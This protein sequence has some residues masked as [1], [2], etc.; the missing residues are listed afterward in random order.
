MPKE[1]NPE[2]YYEYPSGSYVCG[3]CLDEDLART[4][5][6]ELVGDERVFQGMFRRLPDGDTEDFAY[7]CDGCLKQNAA[8]DLLGAEE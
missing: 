2:H 8:Y 4:R 7:Q 1:H 3:S 5:S 6:G